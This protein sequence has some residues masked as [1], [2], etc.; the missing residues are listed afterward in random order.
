[1]SSING[2]LPNKEEMDR[3]LY[4]ACVNLHQAGKNLSYFDPRLGLKLFKMADKIASII[5]AP[6]RKMT[7]DEMDD[8]LNDILNSEN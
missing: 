4:Q 7:D 6:T 1:M 8:M 2:S 5:D 3:M